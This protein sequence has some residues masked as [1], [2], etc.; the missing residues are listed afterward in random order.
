MSAVLTEATAALT[1]HGPAL[2]A[3][4]SGLDSQSDTDAAADDSGSDYCDDGDD[5]VD[6]DEMDV[7]P[8]A[9]N[10]RSAADD[11]EGARALSPQHSTALSVSPLSHLQ[12]C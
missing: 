2:D 10:K 8:S 6:E 3:A 11:A 9:T 5:P 7:K 12:A 4:V 1:L